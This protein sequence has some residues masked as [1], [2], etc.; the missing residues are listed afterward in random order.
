LVGI[1]LALA[2]LKLLAVDLKDDI[3]LPS[4]LVFA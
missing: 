1:F 2:E 3:V 4:D